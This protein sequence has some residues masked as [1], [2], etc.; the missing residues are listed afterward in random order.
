[1]SPRDRQCVGAWR[2]FVMPR[3]STSR[4]DD[5]ALLWD[6][7]SDPLRLTSEPHKIV[8][9]LA[10][11]RDVTI[12]SPASGASCTAWKRDLRPRSATNVTNR[13]QDGS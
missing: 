10:R 12:G 7:S 8:M 11:Y 1:V 2:S 9:Y 5:L 6:Q 13:Q 4:S 3:K